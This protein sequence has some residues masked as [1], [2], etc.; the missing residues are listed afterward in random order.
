MRS[1]KGQ[2]KK[3]SIESFLNRIGMSKYIEVFKNEE[4][5]M[6][7]LV[8]IRYNK[9]KKTRKMIYIL[10][11]LINIY[12]II[13]ASF[14]RGRLQFND[15]TDR[16]SQEDRDSIASSRFEFYVK[17]NRQGEKK[18]PFNQIC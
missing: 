3:K 15:D 7:I 11:F 6:D 13:K 8:L 12:V 14:K 5:D 1:K 10:H 2:H 17:I 16:S 4:I 18:I 9:T